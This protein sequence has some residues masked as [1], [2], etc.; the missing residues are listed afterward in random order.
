MA[1]R[2]SIAFIGVWGALGAGIGVAAEQDTNSVSQGRIVT[3]DTC[4]KVV[5]Y[6][7]VI[8]EALLKCMQDGVPSGNKIGKDQLKEG[9][10][11]EFVDALRA[12]QENEA[13]TND[14]GNVILYGLGG[15]AAGFMLGG[16]P[17]AFRRHVSR[18]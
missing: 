11:I 1:L 9:Q 5:P 2:E 17:E 13:N 6:E 10:P 14:W 15:I 12:S 18:K 4:K 16:G 8:N 7:T 3:I